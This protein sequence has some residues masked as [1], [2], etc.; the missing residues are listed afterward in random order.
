MSTRY[1]DNCEC[2]VCKHRNL[3]LALGSTSYFGSPDL[4]LRPPSPGRS[5]T[6]ILLKECL[7]CGYVALDL[8]QRTEGDTETMALLEYRG[9]VPLEKLRPPKGFDYE[10]P[11]MVYIRRLLSYLR[12]AE[13]SRYLRHAMLMERAGNLE[14]AFQTM[15]W[16]SW[17]GDDND[18]P[19]I[20]KLARSRMLTYSD[21]WLQ[22]ARQPDPQQLIEVHLAMIDAARR[23][24]NWDRGLALCEKTSAFALEPVEF[25][26]VEQQKR[27]LSQRDT[28]CY[29][30]CLE[31]P[32]KA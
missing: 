14:A 5:N 19:D 26:I 6:Q 1:W 12:R 25:Q 13:L 28:H 32:E 3:F 21:E 30:I 24:E 10:A 29:T 18:R 2:A 15:Q 27:L 20:A 4:D 11:N 9:L 16:L 22:S 7:G 8:E 17:W 23:S 31:E